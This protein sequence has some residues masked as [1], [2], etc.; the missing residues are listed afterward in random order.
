MSAATLDLF[1][2]LKYRPDQARDA[3]GRWTSEGR[4]SGAA[5]TH[6]AL[7]NASSIAA[8]IQRSPRSHKTVERSEAIVQTAQN[9][10]TAVKESED[11][12]DDS[13]A[14]HLLET[15]TTVGAAALM[16]YDIGRGAAALFRGSPLPTPI[17]FYVIGGAA[18]VGAALMLYE[19]Y[20]WVRKKRQ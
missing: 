5:S 12:E 7:K 6:H 13:L 9:V 17:T 16:I 2:V 11:D 14:A 15:F 8:E 4:G 3:R 10:L 18:L 20:D 1:E 19:A